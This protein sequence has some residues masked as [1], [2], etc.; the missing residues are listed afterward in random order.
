MRFMLGQTHRS[1]QVASSFSVL[2]M[3]LNHIS[4]LVLLDHVQCIVSPPYEKKNHN[5]I[6]HHFVQQFKLFLLVH[7]YKVQHL[8]DSLLSVAACNAEKHWSV[9]QSS[10]KY[11]TCWLINNTLKYMIN[12]LIIIQP[13]FN[14]QRYSII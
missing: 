3:V 14:L 2:Y 10:R 5:I 8:L 1:V 9:L 4:R 11:K 7:F 13:G 6:Y 12:T